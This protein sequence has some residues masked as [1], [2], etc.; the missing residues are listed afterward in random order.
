MRRA[1]A[2][3]V[4][5]A[6]APCRVDGGGRAFWEGPRTYGLLAGRFGCGGRGRPFRRACGTARHRVG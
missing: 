6:L 4:A 5:E 2:R 3:R 1:L